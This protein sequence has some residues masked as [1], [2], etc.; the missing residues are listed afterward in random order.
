LTVHVMIDSETWGKVPGTADRSIA[1]VTFDPFNWS[2][3]RKEFYRNVIDERPRDPSTVS[4]W[5]QQSQEA[6]AV[7]ADPWPVP[8]GAAL[9]DLFNWF[10]EVGGVFVWSHGIGFDIARLEYTAATMWLTAPWDFRNVCDTRTI[11]RAAA[12]KVTPRAPWTIKHHALHD[13]HNQANAV[14]LAFASLAL[15]KGGW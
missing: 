8:V 12:V 5:A 2:H 7:F 6:Q 13:A 10:R 14:E 9:R 4:W 11:F 15:D 3:P 1:A